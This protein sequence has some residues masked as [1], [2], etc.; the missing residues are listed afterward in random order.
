MSAPRPFRL[1]SV[2]G[3]SLDG[4]PDALRVIRSVLDDYQAR[5]ATL[6]AVSD[7][8]VGIDRM[9]AAEVRRRGTD[10]KSVV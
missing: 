8:A 10:R 7:G 2:G 6:V 1:A 5:H 4:H 9:A 3:R